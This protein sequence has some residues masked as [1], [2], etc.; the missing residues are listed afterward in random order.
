MRSKR[1]RMGELKELGEGL[2]YRHSWARPCK[3]FLG[4]S[5][6]NDPID[7]D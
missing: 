5:S 3:C 4:S 7:K 6:C 2:R 1:E